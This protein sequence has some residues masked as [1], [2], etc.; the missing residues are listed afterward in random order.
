MEGERRGHRPGRRRGGAATVN[1]HRPQRGGGV[2]LQLPL[3]AEA[4][5]KQTGTLSLAARCATPEARSPDQHPAALRRKGGE[6]A[7]K[8]SDEAMQITR[9]PAVKGIAARRKEAASAAF[10]G[11]SGLIPRNARC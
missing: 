10:H 7:T 3:A 9:P 5:A 8:P 6:A 11:G 2:P 1:G 4:G